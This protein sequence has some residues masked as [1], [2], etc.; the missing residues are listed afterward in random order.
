[1][2]TDPR[3]E[4]PAAARNREPIREHLAPLLPEGRTV[5]EIASGSGEHCMHFALRAVRVHFQPSDPDP[6]HRASIDA[7]ARHLGLDNVAPALDLDVT[8]DGWWQV[9]DAQDVALVYCANMI[10]IAPWAAALGL[11]RGAGALLG[12]GERLVLYGPFLRAD[13]ETAPSN[14]AFDDSLRERDP[15]WGIRALEDVEAAAAEHGL[16]REALHAM[17]ANNLLVVFSKRG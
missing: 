2:S 15:A 17:P 1:L 5:L 16:A 6:A 8:A 12:E 7:W 13:V 11:L 10:H 4:W 3:L 9:L 14:R